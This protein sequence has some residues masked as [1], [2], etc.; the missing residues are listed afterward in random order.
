MNT[1]KKLLDRCHLSCSQNSPT[2]YTRQN[3]G[4]IVNVAYSKAVQTN[5]RYSSGCA[6]EGVKVGKIRRRIP[7]SR[8]GGE[9]WVTLGGTAVFLSVAGC[10]CGC[11]LMSDGSTQ[12][13]DQKLIEAWT[14]GPCFYLPINFYVL[15]TLILPTWRIW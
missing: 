8:R 4:C 14:N 10:L 12:R 2:L 13:A 7:W 15:L 11:S 3:T 1:R 9:S 6:G 5:R